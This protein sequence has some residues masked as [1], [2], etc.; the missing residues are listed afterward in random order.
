MQIKPTNQQIIKTKAFTAQMIE[1]GI[2]YAY[3]E[4]RLVLEVEDFEDSMKAYATLSQG[5]AVKAILEFGEYTTATNEARKYAEDNE[6]ISIASAFIIN[7]LAQR[8]LIR[9]YER[10]RRRRNKQPMRIFNNYE[11]ALKWVKTFED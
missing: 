3:F 5:K 9:F 7:G 11:N 1:P 6:P 2:Y 4:P 8:L 10:F